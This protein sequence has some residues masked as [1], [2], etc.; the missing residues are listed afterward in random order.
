M[1]FSW[2]GFVHGGDVRQ[3]SMTTGRLRLPTIRH[4]RFPFCKATS[5]HKVGDIPTS[6]SGVPVV[7]I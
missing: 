7:E 4:L 1:R 6:P 2:D 5:A 3:Q